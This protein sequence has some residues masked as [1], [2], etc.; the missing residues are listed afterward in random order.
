MLFEKKWVGIENVCGKNMCLYLL[1]GRCT[2]RFKCIYFLLSH[3]SPVII[4]VFDVSFDK[5]AHIIPHFLA[6]DYASCFKL[7]SKNRSYEWKC[8]LFSSTFSNEF[9]YYLLI[10]KDPNFFLHYL[11]LNIRNVLNESSRYDN[12]MHN[13]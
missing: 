10:S 3:F 13:F 6:E 9:F 8:H 12:K 1:S 5:L 4:Y 2:K 7:M 11:V